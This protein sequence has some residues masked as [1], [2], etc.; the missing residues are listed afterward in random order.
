MRRVLQEHPLAVALGQ[1]H[2][3][4]RAIVTAQ[5]GQ[6]GQR[7]QWQ[8][9]N[10]GARAFGFEAQVFGGAELV[11]H[12]GCVAGLQA[13]LVGQGGWVCGYLVEAGYDAQG[14]ER[15]KGLCLTRN[16]VRCRRWRRLQSAQLFPTN[17][18]HPL[19]S[20]SC[21]I[22]WGIVEGAEVSTHEEPHVCEGLALQ[23]EDALATR[24]RSSGPPFERH[25]RPV[26][27]LQA[28]RN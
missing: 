4:H 22:C 10:G 2:G 14:G 5:Q 11:V 27:P 21:L 1:H 28:G 17:F 13:Q 9:V 24:D 23:M 12:A 7:A 15:R 25:I 20:P 6:G 18:L 26:A 3:A 16:S 8:A 19:P